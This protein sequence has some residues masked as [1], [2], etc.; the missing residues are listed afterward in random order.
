MQH[1]PSYAENII[2]LVKHKTVYKWF[3][4][5]K[6]IWFLDLKKLAAAFFEKGFKLRN[7]DD[8][9]DRFN[10]AIVNEDTAE[11]FFQ[12]IN[13]FEV[14]TEELKALL[15]HGMYNHISDMVPSLYINVDDKALISCYPEPA[16]YEDYVPNGWSGEYRPFSQDIP[17]HYCYWIINGKNLFL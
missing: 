11:L 14:A 10:I 1:K 5:D 13:S 6:E 3:V 16:S 7:P 4:A 8:F 17:Q 2:V 12:A 15:Q 9:S